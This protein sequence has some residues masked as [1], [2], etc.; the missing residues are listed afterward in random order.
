LTIVSPSFALKTGRGTDFSLGGSAT[1]VHPGNGST[2]AAELS[3]IGASESHVN[4][5]IPKGLK[6][7]DLTA[8]ATDYRFVV[9][10]CAAG[11]PR[12]TAN[13]TDGTRQR[14]VFFYIGVPPSTCAGGTY[15]YS[16]NLAAPSSIVDAHNLPG[17]S[18]EPFSAV[19]ANY[20][21]YAVTAVHIDVDGGENGNQTVDFDNTVVNG[22]FVSYEPEHGISVLMERAAGKIKVKEPGERGFKN[23]KK[24]E[25]IHVNSVVDT[26]GGKIEVTAATGNFAETTPDNPMAFYDGL[27]RIKQGR[28]HNA[29]AT[30]KLLGKLQCPEQAGGQPRAGTSS[31]PVATTSRKRRRRVWGSGSGNYATAGKGGTGSVLGTT[32]LTKD[33]CKG[34]L[35]KV[36]EG[37][38]VTVHDFGLDQHIQIGPGQKYFARNR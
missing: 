31:G 20:G 21:N 23:L 2:T 33:T 35:F 32:W 29:R 26:R 12:F 8:L 6:L 22:K 24:V 25:S 17:G 36:I 16:G 4:I 7:R 14:S 15:T 1:V 27:I 28:G 34:T 37:I 3:A 30:A 11:S 19:Q 18:S 13:V 5:A 38:G 10:T 9:G